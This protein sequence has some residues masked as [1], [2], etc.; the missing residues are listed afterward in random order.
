MKLLLHSLVDPGK[1]SILRPSRSIYR[2][3][4]FALTLWSLITY[5]LI[6]W[7]DRYSST[8]KDLLDR[9]AP[10]TT[11][12]SR[13]HLLTPWFDTECRFFKRSAKR[14]ERVYRRNKTTE[15][16]LAWVKTLQAMRSF[17]SSR[18]NIHIG[19]PRLPLTPKHLK[20]IEKFV[21]NPWQGKVIKQH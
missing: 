18:R 21:N 9:H 16:R 6:N 20:T 7:F 14:L 3:V 19:Q 4:N 15:N 12:K 11:N 8:L 1:D 10:Y 2:W 17:F 13:R 5:Q